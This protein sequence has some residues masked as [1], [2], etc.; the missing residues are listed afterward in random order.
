MTSAGIQLHVLSN[1]AVTILGL[2][3]QANQYIEHCWAGESI[4][5][6]CTHQCSPILTL[7]TAGTPSC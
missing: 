1:A 5:L 6:Q 7:C 2:L 3:Q 4:S